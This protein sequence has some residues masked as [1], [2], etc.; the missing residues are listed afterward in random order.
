MDGASSAIAVVSITIQLADSVR[1]LYDF[2]SSVKD[3]PEDV[4]GI[5]T[6][7]E[8]LQSVFS[9]IAY[10]AQH[11]EPNAILTAVLWNCNRNVEKLFAILKDIEPG[12]ASASLTTRKWS[13]IKF[14][15]KEGKV[16]KFQDIIERLKSSLLLAQ[17]TH[18]G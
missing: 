18:H 9:N 12:F 8:L 13:A 14:V 17:Q 15:F 5:T 7:L 1:K 6:D 10:D 4:Q 16:K 3:A 2:W 11:G